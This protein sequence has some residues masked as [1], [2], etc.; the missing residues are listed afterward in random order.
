MLKALTTMEFFKQ[1]EEERLLYEARQKWLHDYA[2]A[3]DNA[4][5]LGRE[6]GLAVARA[7]GRRETYLN[8]AK[9]MLEMGFSQEKIIQATGLS[10]DEVQTLFLNE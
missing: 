7:D 3:I 6:L 8:I 10:T 5:E 9:R 2:S 1:D 4:T